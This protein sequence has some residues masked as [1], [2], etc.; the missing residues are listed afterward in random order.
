M[1]AAASMHARMCTRVGACVIN[2]LRRRHLTSRACVCSCMRAKWV[3]LAGL[4]QHPVL[5]TVSVA[6]ARPPQSHP[7]GRNSRLTFHGHYPMAELT[8][9]QRE[10]RTELIGSILRF[11]SIRLKK[12]GTRLLGFCWPCQCVLPL[13]HSEAPEWEL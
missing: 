3:C 6:C 12:I 5:A 11:A 9:H 4:A 1:H 8:V 2:C 7:S 10:I 13:L